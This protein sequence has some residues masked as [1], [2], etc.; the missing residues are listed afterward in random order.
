[1]RN[2]KLDL[3]KFDLWHKIFDYLKMNHLV[4]VASVSKHFFFHASTDYLYPKFDLELEQESEEY[5]NEMQE[6]DY[7]SFRST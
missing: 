6:S 1:M 7:S 5:E 4:K 3:N 2:G